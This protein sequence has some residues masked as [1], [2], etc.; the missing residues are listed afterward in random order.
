MA[1]NSREF[2]V[3][4][5]RKVVEHWGLEQKKNVSKCFRAHFRQYRV[6]WDILFFATIS[7]FLFVWFNLRVML[8]LGS[9]LGLG[10]GFV[11][12]K[13]NVRC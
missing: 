4:P 8:D 12:A 1:G 3:S 10:L 9:S 6:D 2:S 13:G 5:E 11:W 7:F